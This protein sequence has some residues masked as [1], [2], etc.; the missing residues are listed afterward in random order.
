M[1]QTHQLLREPRQHQAR[2]A[3]HGEQHLAQRLGLARI[4]A[5]RRRPVVGQAEGPQ[6]LQ[7]NGDV[8][9]PLADDIGGLLGRETGARDHRA[10][11]QRVG[12][13]GALGE[14]AHDLGRL[15]REAE[16]RWRA[17][18]GTLEC[19]TRADDGVADRGRAE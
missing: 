3:H 6:A 10:R 4:E 7:C 17:R 5:V 12:E 19:G 1:A 8:G 2:V 11:E 13:L 14:S 15:G 9:G 18:T 16:I